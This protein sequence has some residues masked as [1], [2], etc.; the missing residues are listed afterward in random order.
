MC[1]CRCASSLWHDRLEVVVRQ[2]RV[3]YL[4]IMPSEILFERDKVVIRAMHRAG[5]ARD[6]VQH[7]TCVFWQALLHLRLA[8][9]V[10]VVFLE[11][12]Q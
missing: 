8:L 3:S 6:F 4:V 7:H 5:P 1:P 11:P 10:D 2:R 9:R 12:R